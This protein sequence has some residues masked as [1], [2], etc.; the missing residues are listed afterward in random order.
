MQCPNCGTENPD[1][2]QS[3][4]SCNWLLTSASTHMPTPVAKTSGLAITSFV[5]AFLSIFT[6]SLTMIPAVIF[7]IAGLV[8]IC[9]SRGKLKGNGFA[10]AGIAISIAPI[11][12]FG[13]SLIIFTFIWSLDAPPI[14]DDY[15]I[16]DLR[17]APPECARSYELLMSLS[18]E[19]ECPL[20][21][22]KIGLSEQDVNTIEQVNEVIKESDYSKIADA[23]KE[24][25]DDIEQLWKNGQKGRDIIS[26][27]NTFPE[28]ADLT[29][30]DLDV[31]MKLL[32]NL[33]HLVYL[34]QAYVYLQTEQGNSIDAVNELNKLDSVFRKL[35]VNVRPTVTKL[36]CIA[37]W[38]QVQGQQT[39]S[40]TTHRLP[41]IHSS[42]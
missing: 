38:I 27:L 42:F 7:G 16:A 9:N 6:L 24:K 5:L 12:L 41:K 13:V 1:N 11:I 32:R 34:Y 28:I 21:A 3:C 20:D 14:P 40:Q 17:S 18:E 4:H 25:A 22:P 30:P 2:A 39:L 8:K 35:S 15:T 36:V 10:V 26:E 23:L 29:E 31:E 33:R 19:Q 37:G